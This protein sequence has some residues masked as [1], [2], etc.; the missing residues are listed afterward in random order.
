MHETYVSLMWPKGQWQTFQLDDKAM[1]DLDISRVMDRHEEQMTDWLR[2][3]IAHLPKD[4]EV[5]LYRQ[6]VLRDFDRN[7]QLLDGFLEVSQQ[8]TEFRNIIK[9]AFERDPALYNVLKRVEESEAILRGLYSLKDKMAKSVV[10][11]KGLRDFAKMLDELIQSDLFRAYEEDLKVI[12]S[13][14]EIRGIKVGLNLDENMNP[15]EAIVLTLEEETFHYSRPMKTMRR[16]LKYGI[17][18]VKKIPRR[19]FAPET[20]I[21][22]ENLNALEKVIAPAM[23]Q[24]LKFIDTFNDALLDVFEPL[25]DELSYYVLANHMKQALTAAGYPV[26]QMS[27]HEGVGHYIKGLYNVNLA[28][29]FMTTGETMVYNDVDWL[30]SHMYILTGPNRGGKTTY[31]QSMGQI[32]WLGLLGFYVGA[33]SVNMPMID[34]LYVHFPSEEKETVLFGRLGEECDRFA[35]MFGDMTSRSL[36]LMNETFSGTSHSES[37]TIAKGALKAV[38]GVGL[39]GLFNTHLHELAADVDDLNGQVDQEGFNFSNLVSGSQEKHQSFVI[40]EGEPFGK[41]YAHEIAVK[42]GVSYKQL[43]EGAPEK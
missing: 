18:E 12:R 2:E 31:T 13:K 43:M 37:L 25:K 38:S 30:G 16:V 4:E 40:H 36:L 42:Y 3:A 19:I 7:S 32:Y 24:L 41:S 34:G 39:S 11:S 1:K 5:V 21:P 33:R 9:F 29:H 28:Y 27:F 35:K 10:A 26:C 23:G 20:V 8:F 22:K 15:V 17:S 14:K 6:E